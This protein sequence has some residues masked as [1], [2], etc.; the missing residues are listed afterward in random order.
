[1]VFKVRVYKVYPQ[2]YFVLQQWSQKYMKVATSQGQPKV[3]VD[4]LSQ[5]S[6]ALQSLYWTSDPRSAQLP[7]PTWAS[8]LSKSRLLCCESVRLMSSG[9]VIGP[10]ALAD[11]AGDRV[12]AQPGGGAVLPGGAAVLAAPP[13]RELQAAVEGR[14][15]GRLLHLQTQR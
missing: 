11:G 4:F 14:P 13:H 12:P 1:M 10:G 15:G 6:H 2:K 8:L 9:S 5:F 7:E 3:G